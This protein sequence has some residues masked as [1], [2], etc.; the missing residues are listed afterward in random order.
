[1][2]YVLYGNETFLLEQKLNDLK[3][4][5]QISESMMNL[6]VYD[7]PYV[8]VKD[9][10]E[11]CNTPPFLT[12]Y[13]MVVIKNPAF[14]T[15]LKIPEKHKQ[16]LTILE[17]YIKNPFN[18]T[19]L[20]IISTIKNYDERKKV[21]KLLRNE[22]TFVSLDE[23]SEQQLWDL[24]RQAFKKRQCNI[25]DDA[26]RLLLSRTPHQLMM[27]VNE[28]EKLSLYSNQITLNDVDRLVSK[29]LEENAFEL[30]SAIMKKNQKLAISIYQDLMIQNE[31]PVKLVVMIGNQIRLL[32]QVK[33]LERKGYT[34]Q[35]MAKILAINP[36]RVK[37]IR[38]DARIFELNDLLDKLNELACLDRNIKQ[39]LI[40]KKLGL[41][42]FLIKV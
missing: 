13:K 30:V 41:E 22:S 28:V 38:N 6:S 35:E 12:E 14:L 8:N 29:P 9:I 33:L 2:I 7:D 19:V 25:E 20:V 37:Y 36:F 17:N 39:G 24:T 4:K 40:D 15:T 11:D 34:D 18:Q 32:Y 26:L 5:Y 3:K 10:V 27:I 23:L 21:V 31:E 1:M 42:L 16:D